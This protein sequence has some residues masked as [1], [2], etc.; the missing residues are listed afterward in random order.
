MCRSILWT[1]R[2][3][4]EMQEHPSA[5]LRDA[6]TA[7]ASL[8]VPSLQDVAKEHPHIARSTQPEQ[9][10]LPDPKPPPPPPCR[11]W[12]DTQGSP[13]TSRPRGLLWAHPR[14]QGTPVLSPQCHPS[15]ADG[16]PLS[17]G[18]GWQ[19]GRGWHPSPG[20]LRGGALGVPSV[21]PEHPQPLGEA[22]SRHPPVHFLHRGHSCP[23]LR[24]PPQVSP[25][26]TRKEPCEVEG[27]WGFF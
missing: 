22:G 15:P 14:P 6:G 1:Q 8:G 9:Q 13:G 18:L 12:G 17:E 19:R 5:S 4:Q 16:A 11:L 20:G 27:L 7:G 2:G 10:Q 3:M 24:P 23:H 21:P 26:K 25:Q